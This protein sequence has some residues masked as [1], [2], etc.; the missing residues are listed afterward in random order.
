MRLPSIPMSNDFSDKVHFRPWI[1]ANYAQDSLFDK[2]I[3]LL[4]ESHYSTKFIDEPK[5]I[6]FQ[7]TRH[8]M[9][10]FAI[11]KTARFYTVVRKLLLDAARQQCDNAK[12]SRV[13][14][15]SF[16]HSVAFYNY[17]QEFVGK[18]ARIRPSDAQWLRNENAFFEV[19]EKLNPDVCVVLGK[20]LWSN[21]PKKYDTIIDSES[22]GKFRSYKI[23]NKQILFAHTAHPSSLI[24]Y[25]KG[26]PRVARLLQLL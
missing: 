25:K 22:G 6:T 18:K 5:E 4:G 13:E 12:L 2:K 8:I 20:E 1:G 14:K 19:L 17:V 9:Q 11:D 15:H 10:V 23:E 7:Y 16:W 3:L 24:S 21:L 26:I